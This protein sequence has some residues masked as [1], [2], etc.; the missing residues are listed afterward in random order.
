[1]DTVLT[2]LG[3][4]LV[5]GALTG[6][7]SA[8][9]VDLHAFRTWKQASDVAQYDWGTAALRWAQGVVSGV[10]VAGGLAAV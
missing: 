10:L 9:I 1:M 4:P 6:F 2:I 7:A 8:A 3:N 5:K